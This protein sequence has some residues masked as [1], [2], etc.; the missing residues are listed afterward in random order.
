MVSPLAT[1]RTVPDSLSASYSRVLLVNPPQISMGGEYMMEDVPIRLE[2]LAAYIKDRVQHVN[3]I[4]LIRETRP[5]EYYLGRF[6][7]DLVGI[8]INYVSAHKNALDLADI[9]KSFGADVVVGGYQAT[10]MAEDMALHP[11]IDYVVMGEGE[12]TLMDIIQKK[13]K[14][15]IDGICYEEDGRPVTTQWRPHIQDLDSIPFPDRSARKKPYNSPFMD[16]ENDVSTGYDIIITSRGCW[17]KCKFCTEPMMSRGE[18]RYR[19]AEK[20]VEELEQI[21]RLHRGKKRL[22]IIISDPNFGGKPKVTEELCDRLIEFRARCRTDVHFFVTVRTSTIANHET[23]TK[24]MVAAGMDYVFVGMESPKK[25]DLDAISKPGGAREKQELA[26]KYLRENGAAMM[27]CFLLGLPGQ[28]EKD[29]LSLV[30]YAKE[31]DLTDAYF[32]VMTPLPGSKLYDEALEQGL[33]LEK[34]VTKYRLWDML[35]EHDH[36][37]R[38]KIR[39]LCVRLNAKYYDDVMLRQEYQRWEIT[40]GRKKKLYTYI[41]KFRMF[42]GFINTLNENAGEDFAD[43]DPAMFVKDMPNTELRKLTEGNK[44]SNVLDMGRFLKILGRQKIQ[45]SLR[46]NE[47][48]TVSW[49]VKTTPDH[50]EYMDSI[51]GTTNDTS[52]NISV[53]LNNGDLSV[54]SVIGD[55]LRQNSGI[56]AKLN[57]FRLVAAI[58][59]ETAAWYTAK[60]TESLRCSLYSLAHTS[61]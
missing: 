29:V 6:R 56:R 1:V 3:M 41:G 46:L 59:A 50:V 23:L 22:R 9:A 44:V 28:T 52:I 39:E 26:V 12:E 25:E 30:D 48:D 4:D 40:G 14:K 38:A 11:S 60:K 61:R 53:P 58:G 57:L 33:L 16:L 21:V 5:L 49:V 47:E 15:Q 42:T 54:K 13:P 35:I 37:S 34:D 45:V 18:Q 24:K 19:S 31:L 10:A 27:T 43:F 55:V 8:S 36:L 20:V 2:Y 17:G 51:N 32:S 7:P